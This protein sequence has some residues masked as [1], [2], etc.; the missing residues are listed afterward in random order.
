MGGIEL[1][2]VQ[3]CPYKAADVTIITTGSNFAKTKSSLQLRPLRKLDDYSK[4][5]CGSVS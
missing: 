3:E 2:K 5:E 4:Q 1:L